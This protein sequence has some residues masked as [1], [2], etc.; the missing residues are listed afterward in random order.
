VL[1][2][3]FDPFFTTKARG[4]GTGLGL[5]ISFGIV[6]QHEG[7]IEVQTALG[8]GTCFSVVLPSGG[9]LGGEGGC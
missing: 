8:Q 1:R 9:I 2:H 7:N 6:K 5:A 4:R 3:I